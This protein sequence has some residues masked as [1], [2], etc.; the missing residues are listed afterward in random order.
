MNENFYIRVGLS[1]SIC[2]PNDF[3]AYSLSTGTQLTENLLGKFSFDIVWPELAQFCKHLLQMF[4]SLEVG[5][6]LC[7]INHSGLC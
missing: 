1:Y 6:K 5:S 3:S 7:E 4:K 2:W